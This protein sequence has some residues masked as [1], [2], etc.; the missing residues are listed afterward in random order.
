MPK[1]I[2]F[3]LKPDQVDALEKA[4]QSD[5]R[6]GVVRRATAVRL[7]HLGYA[8]PVVAEMVTASEPIVY[9]WHAHFCA[10]GV[11]GLANQAQRQP[12]RKVTPEYVRLL[13]ET[14]AKEPNECGYAFAIWTRER[15]V[16]HLAQAT[17]IRID[18]SW[19]QHLLN[20][21]GYVCRRPKHDLTQRQD[22]VAKAAAQD[23]LEAL[24]K[25]AHRTSTGSS[26]WMK[27]A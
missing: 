27:Q 22:A 21:L 20:Q 5:K 14:L 3:Q 9:R 4:I 23:Q 7:L 10:R 1:R 2:N 25:T 16:V 12:S 19:L 26:L 17:G 24:K 6:T 13:E 11:D 18:V 15:L 8:V